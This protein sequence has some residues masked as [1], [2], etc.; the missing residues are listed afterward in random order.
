MTSA[1]W[2]GSLCIVAAMVSVGCS[3]GD[4]GGDTTDSGASAVDGGSSGGASS[5]GGSSSGGADGGG[6]AAD[7]STSDGG[8]APQDW[9]KGWQVLGEDA[10]PVGNLTSVWSNGKS[11]TDREWLLVGGSLAGKKE[12]VIWELRGDKW[13]KHA[14]EGVGLLWWVHGDIDGRRIAVGDGGTIVRWTSGDKTLKAD[15]VPGLAKDKSQLFG[16]WF[17]PKGETFWVVGGN[18][19]GQAKSGLLW[20]VPFAAKDGAEVETKATKIDAAGKDG[21]LMK[22]WGTGEAGKE[23]LFAVGEEGRIWSNGGGKWAEETKVKIDRL[24]GVTGLSA[25]NVVAVGGLGTGGVARRDAKGWTKAAGCTKCFINGNLAAVILTPGGAAVVGGSHGYL[26]VQQGDTKDKDLPTV[27]PPLSE[28]D[29]HGAWRDEHT[30]VVVGG[31]LSNPAVAAGV[32]LYRGAAL[33][34]LPK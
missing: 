32:V 7:G 28:L 27:D 33:P 30:A 4:T 8:A 5:G 19:S 15:P 13:T 12:A 18:T 23:R 25:D 14:L 1:R 3:N 11:G 2:Y 21:L 24:I 26:A 22:V 9:L 16:T 31:N 29:L 17:A 20:E 34:L 10:L 6:Q